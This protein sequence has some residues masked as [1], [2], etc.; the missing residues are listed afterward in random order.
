M[1]DRG[2]YCKAIWAIGKWELTPHYMEL[3]TQLR[4]HFGE[5]SVL[6][7]LDPSGMEGFLH[8][9]LFQ[10]QTFP[11][12]PGSSTGG[13]V[14]TLRRLTY[15]RPYLQVE[16][17]GV[18]KTR[19]GLFLCGYPSWD[20]NNLRQ[21]I[22]QEFGERGYALVEPHPQDIA[23]ATLM[24][25]VGELTEEEHI[26]LNSLVEEN[27]AKPIARFT[28]LRWEYGFGTWR[29]LDEERQVIASWPAHPRWILHRGLAVGP[30]HAL[31]NNEDELRRRLD[32]GW[33]IECD[34]WYGDDEIWRLGHDGPGEVLRDVDGLLRHPRSWIHCKNLVALRKC[35]E[36]RGVNCFFHDT[37]TAVLTSQQYIWAYPGHI[38]EGEK[39]VCVMPERHG[40]TLAEICNVGAVCSDYLPVKFAGGFVA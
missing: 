18:S 28:P 5:R 12:T 27:W 36:M 32:E 8:W 15:S 37:D 14:D 39:G 17:K 20:V 13:E 22:R 38:V 19:H 29:Q 6:Y 33:E 16:F 10:T 26:W 3:I 35:I 9:T 31:E 25:L 30:N 11:V 23:H 24:R 2:L 4:E 34:V 21:D 40:F 1:C 7:T